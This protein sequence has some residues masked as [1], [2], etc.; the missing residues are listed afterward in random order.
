M[1][2]KAEGLGKE[3]FNSIYRSAT[4]PWEYESSWYEQRKYA[5]TLSALPNA[6]Y[7]RA[8]EAG[9]SFG[10]LS[11]RLAARCDSLVCFDFVQSVA[12]RAKNRL[13]GLSHVE[14]R[15]AELTTCWP[16]PCGDLVLWSEVAYYLGES[17]RNLAVTGLE[18]W[19]LPKGHLVTVNY[20]EAMDTP[21]SG[22][23][24]SS[25]LDSVEFLKRT[26]WYTDNT[27]E[28]SIWERRSDK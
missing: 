5:V 22:A 11:E 24:V 28:L 21:L 17:A 2:T 3:Y 16:E 12:L 9:C 10:V 13:K 4:D 27:F 7:R 8:L 20:T 19:L 23:E 6:R 18:K 26:A 1:E 15:C 14:V 25:W